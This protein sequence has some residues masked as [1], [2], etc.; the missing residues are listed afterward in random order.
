MVFYVV[1]FHSSYTAPMHDFYPAHTPDRQMP[2]PAE[3]PNM[4][5]VLNRGIQS[6]TGVVQ[7]L[8]R[9][10][11]AGPLRAR[12]VLGFGL[13]SSTTLT[14]PSRVRGKTTVI[15]RVSTRHGSA[16]ARQGRR[17]EAQVSLKQG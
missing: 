2:E 11:D 10:C 1:L 16:S 17:I 13:L 8:F 7:R 15:A 9:A 6:L 3:V 12:V 14:T 4:V 5:S